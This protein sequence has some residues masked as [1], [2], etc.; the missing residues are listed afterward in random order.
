MSKS[1]DSISKKR[2]SNTA[3][4]DEDTDNVSTAS[5]DKLWWHEIEELSPLRIHVPSNSVISRDTTSSLN[6]INQLLP[7]TI[8]N[9]S[10]LLVYPPDKSNDSSNIKGQLSAEIVKNN[11]L[12]T[13]ESEKEISIKKKKGLLTIGDR[14][15]KQ[16][17]FFN[18]LNLK[19]RRISHDETTDISHVS[20]NLSFNKMSPIKLQEKEKS[21]KED[22]EDSM[23]D[24]PL[25]SRPWLLRKTLEEGNNLTSEKLRYIMN[26]SR[27]SDGT[28]NKPRLRKSDGR[29]TDSLNL[30]NKSPVKA[31]HSNVEQHV[32]S[33]SVNTP[34]DNRYL[35]KKRR[36]AMQSQV[37]YMQE[38]KNSFEAVFAD[39]S[40]A[41]LPR[42]RDMIQEGD[43]QSV[44]RDIED[45]MPR[46]SSLH[47]EIVVDDSESDF[48]DN[49]Q[50][51]SPRSKFFKA[52][53]KSSKKTQDKIKQDMLGNLSPHVYNVHNERSAI[54]KPKTRM[55]R[56]ALDIS[57]FENPFEDVLQEHSD[58]SREKNINMSIR[59]RASP[60]LDVSIYVETSSHTNITSPKVN[61]ISR[62]K[63]RN[64]S[65][66]VI[67][68]KRSSS[69][70]SGQSTP[71]GRVQGAAVRPGVRLSARSNAILRLFDQDNEIIR[72]K[73][74]ANPMAMPSKT[75]T[76]AE[77]MQQIK[78]R[79]EAM[80]S[81]ELAEMKMHAGKI[82][83]KQLASNV[84]A[85]GVVS[86]RIMKKK[87][88]PVTSAKKVDPAYL[89]NG[90]VYKVPKLLR[91]KQWATD[92]LYKFLWK[93]LETKYK[94]STRIR[95]EKFVGDLSKIVTLIL[96][97]KKYNSYKT[98]LE[99]LMKE[100]ARLQ[101]INTRNDFYNFCR[102]FMPYEFRVKVI[103]ILLPGNQKTIPYDPDKLHTSLLDE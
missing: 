66:N 83:K 71:D 73:K 37:Q 39:N 87:K 97:R 68:P 41:S 74:R 13:S 21:Q 24:I 31:Q 69:V 101:I 100:M 62:E 15:S 29:H 75:F 40:D 98:E 94:L 88:L 53:R 92:R 93:C 30:S 82:D 59:N 25:K 72:D 76:N 22:S 85:S 90:E 23:S 58:S 17:D 2:S 49:Q 99:A 33:D 35:F 60:E 16:N 86:G 28:L 18:V 3:I 102:D 20:R 42:G 95:S 38:K 65:E 81:R 91:P 70:P 34:E 6:T 7:P 11:V 50:S 9:S 26:S 55:M 77:K 47:S 80:K 27:C 12:E 54:L 4:L 61:S 44:T 1:K 63:L 36:L 10:V 48:S 46:V 67:P 78:E 45:Q 8:R 64:I 57:S 56:R 19:K 52:L 79:V 14:M 89:V 51:T 43:T 84:K 5:T 103:P 32:M 96:R